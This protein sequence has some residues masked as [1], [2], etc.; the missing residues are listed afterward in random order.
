[1]VAA[2]EATIRFEFAH[3]GGRPGSGGMGTILV[4]GRKVP[5]ARIDRTQ[6]FIFSA[7]EGADVEMDG[8]TP[9]TD[10]YE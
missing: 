5:G 9:V 10:D 3:D 6:P 7:D 1:V 2:A 4:N 8:G